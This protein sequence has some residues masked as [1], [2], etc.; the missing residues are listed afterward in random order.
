MH[1]SLGRRLQ[2]RRPPQAPPAPPW[3]GQAP[4]R[5]RQLLFSKMQV[6]TQ[7]GLLWGVHKPPRKMPGTWC[8]LPGSTRLV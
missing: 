7:L 3:T 1:A 5:L 6:G 2:P 4:R 8:P